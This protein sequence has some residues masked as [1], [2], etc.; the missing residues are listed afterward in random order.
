MLGIDPGIRVTGYGV[1]AVTDGQVQYMDSGC[2]RT[3][4]GADD[5]S[6]LKEIYEGVNQ[7]IN[8]YQPTEGIIEKI[9]TCRNASSALKLGQARGVAMACMAVKEMPVTEY[10]S[11][12]IKQAVT[13]H[14]GAEKTQVRTMVTTL[15]QLQ[16][17]IAKDA[18]DAL[19]TALCHYQSKQIFA[20]LGASKTVR[21]R[22][23]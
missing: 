9:F 20:R 3:Q 21:G 17:R 2:I 16:N 7:I 15:L 18:A 5:A 4:G 11:K 14:G 1:I 6:R 8:D 12:Q 10:S 22:L 13:G 23:Q 19:A